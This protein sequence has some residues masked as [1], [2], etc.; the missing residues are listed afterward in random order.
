MGGKGRGSGSKVETTVA[1][2]GR[3][4]TKAGVEHIKPP[5]PPPKKGKPTKDK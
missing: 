1:K 2:S 3:P 4:P 5:P